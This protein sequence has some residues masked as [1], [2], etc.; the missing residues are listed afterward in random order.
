[1]KV[2]FK[3]QTLSDLGVFFKLNQKEMKS[4]NGGGEVE[5]I[6]VYEDG[7]IVSKIIIK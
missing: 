4:I 5:S 7:K 3:K 6:L 1:M 2:N